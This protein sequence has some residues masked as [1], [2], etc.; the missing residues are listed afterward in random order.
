LSGTFSAKIVH[1]NRIGQDKA[2]IRLRVEKGFS[3]SAGQYVE[4]TVGACDPRAYSIANAPGQGDLEI[5]IRDNGRGGVGTYAMQKMQAGEDVQLKGP[6]GNCVW[7]KTGHK[8]L[9]LI[10]GGMGIAPLKAIAE[11]ALAH[12][13]NGPVILYWGANQ[14]EDMYIDAEIGLL[15]EKNRNFHYIPII[16]RLVGE[17]A[18]AREEDLQDADI[19][20]AGPPA[21]ISAVIPLLLDKGAQRSAIHTDNVAL[22]NATLNQQNKT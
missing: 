11:E 12:D 15:A 2:I 3:Y 7:K 19:F 6:F 8:R 10:A 22:L 9:V 13:H 16:N 1:I 4:L 5:H 21:M 20:L 18:H 17:V 14:K